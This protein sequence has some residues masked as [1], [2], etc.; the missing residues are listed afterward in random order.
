M[1]LR[2][3][4][5]LV[6]LVVVLAI[7]GISVYL[8]V[9]RITSP[10]SEEALVQKHVKRVARLAKSARDLAFCMHSTHLLNV[11]AQ[12]GR[13]WVTCEAENDT[14]R[15]LGR[16]LN[17]SGVLPEGLSFELMERDTPLLAAE[18]DRVQIPFTTE[19]C[20]RPI[21]VSIVGQGGHRASIHID[22]N[23]GSLWDSGVTEYE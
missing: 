2:Y 23:W 13:Y 3:A 21:R 17:L 11:D 16:D 14:Q 9:P 4:F 7:L 18:S 5:T 15:T 6:E 10:T 1:R 22:E 8:V 19:G 12:S 20:L